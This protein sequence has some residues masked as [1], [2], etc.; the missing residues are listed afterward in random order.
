MS[1]TVDEKFV[2]NT[3]KAIVNEVVVP[4]VRDVVKEE[5]RIHFEHLYKVALREAKEAS[6]P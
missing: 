6:K 3:I 2:I 4:H 1:V 5:M